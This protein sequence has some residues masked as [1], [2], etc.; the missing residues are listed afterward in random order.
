MNFKRLATEAARIE[1]QIAH[2]KA[3]ESL[4]KAELELVKSPEAKRPEIQ[5]KVEAARLI[6]IA[7]KKAIDEPG[8]N[9]TVPR[10]SLKTKE[11]NIETDASRF[12]PFPPK[13]TGRRTALANWIADRS[14]PLTARVIVN[15]LWLRHFG[16]PLVGT[17]F[18]FG[19]KGAKPTHPEL[20]DWLAVEL[21]E[22]H[23]SLKHLHRLMV[24]SEAYR[25][26]SSAEKEMVLTQGTDPEN[27]YLWRM[28][29]KRMEAQAIRDSL[30]HLAGQL[31]STFGGPSLS[32]ASQGDSRRRS[33]YFFHSHNEHHKFLMQFDDA[34][35]LECYRR[36][37]SIVP[38]QAL[39]L[40]NSRFSLQMCE[41]IE[42]RFTSRDDDALI[43]EAFQLLLGSDPSGE[44]IAA[45]RDALTE[46]QTVL[47]EQKHPNPTGKARANLIAA[48]I[49][50]NDFVTVR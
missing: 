5:K 21:M 40:A 41:Q 34:G 3:E 27:R 13:S 45:C 28:N 49:N 29:S 6:V 16:Q 31:D 24:T 33:L 30:L 47:K 7:A 11:S 25:L 18:D 14:N 26:S 44:E 19:R 1:K 43:R 23:W 10:G 35:V 38:Q 37:E 36:T 9:Y 46:W 39:T 17:V 15:H 32:V 4:L 50:H 20:L 48:I 12:K 42:S 2:A 8:E 22:H